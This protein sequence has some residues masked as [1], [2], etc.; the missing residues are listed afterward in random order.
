MIIA[1]HLLFHLLSILHALS[2]KC[3]PSLPNDIWA[4]M[5]RTYNLSRRFLLSID[6]FHNHIILLNVCRAC[7]VRAR[8]SGVVSP[9]PLKR[10]PRHLATTTVRI[11]KPSTIAGGRCFSSSLRLKAQ[12]SFSAFVFLKVR[13]GRLQPLRVLVPLICWSRKRCALK[14]M[15]LQ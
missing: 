12:T 1:T 10:W 7:A 8:K 4:K 15:R 14:S 9:S 13:S 3:Q 6:D 11:V 5:P 2:S